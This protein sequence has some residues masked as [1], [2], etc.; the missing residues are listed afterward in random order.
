MH[1]I[2]YE[3]K[4]IAQLVP[5]DEETSKIEEITEGCDDSTTNTDY[6]EECKSISAD[7]PSQLGPLEGAVEKKSLNNNT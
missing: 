1:L 6:K 7:A 3:R 2:A 5:Q 4:N